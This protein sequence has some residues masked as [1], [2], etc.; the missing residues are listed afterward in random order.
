M[1]KAGL[2]YHLDQLLG[3]RPL[4]YLFC[5]H[6]L[7]RWLLKILCGLAHSAN[8]SI[9]GSIDLSI[10]RLWLEILFGYTDFPDGHG[11]YICKDAGHRFEGPYGLG[12][13]AITQRER[14]IGLGLWVCGYELILSMSEFPVRRFD[15]RSVIYRPFELHT[16][17]LEYEKSVCFSWQGT[18]D[19]GTISLE[20]CNILPDHCACLSGAMLSRP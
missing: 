20:V 3:S 10:P 8:L 12:L 13:R 4:L 15:G 17:G 5:G 2:P 19:L 14:L 6:D 1:F 16:I 9:N 11:L 18:A 7:E